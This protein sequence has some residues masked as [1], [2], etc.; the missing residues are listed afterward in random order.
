MLC[1]VPTP[2]VVTSDTTSGVR[3]GGAYTPE[4]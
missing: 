2:D 3:A 1:G 4:W